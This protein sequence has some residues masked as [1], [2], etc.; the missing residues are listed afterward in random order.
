MNKIYLL[1]K[2][3]SDI[4]LY[5]ES[6]YIDGL[7]KVSSLSGLKTLGLK[8]SAAKIFLDVVGDRWSFVIA[9]WIIESVVGNKSFKD[10]YSFFHENNAVVISKILNALD[11]LLETPMNKREFRFN[12]KDNSDLSAL[13]IHMEDM[14]YELSKLWEVKFYDDYLKE[15]YK[16]DSIHPDEFIASLINYF[17]NKLDTEIKLFL[18]EDFLI[19]VIENKFISVGEAKKLSLEDARKKF[20]KMK[21]DKMPVILTMDDGW[22]WVDAGGGRSLWVRENLKNCGSC[23]WGNLKATEESAKEAK[24]LV[25]VDER[26]RPHGIVTWNPKYAEYNYEEGVTDNYLGHI[27]GVASNPL[28]QD[29]YKYFI[30]L[31]NHIKPTKMYIK[32]NATYYS[33][34]TY[35]DNSELK[36]ALK[37]YKIES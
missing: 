37:E 31:V 6:N 20:N 14:R 7:I 8:D 34:G 29:Y 4:G 15:L 2:A 1:S 3:L 30:Q 18:D 24:M 16:K 25:L 23:M 21:E 33:D 5:K 9:K 12:Q 28:K 36:E 10:Y 19:S 13:K 22:R 32:N 27:E 17:K 26:Y 11:V 35:S